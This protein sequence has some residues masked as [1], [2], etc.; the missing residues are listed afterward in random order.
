MI[1]LHIHSNYSDGSNTVVEILK[2]SE[3]AKLDIISITDH[4]TC[5]AYRDVE[6]HK[7]LF[8]GSI[9]PGIEMTT[10]FL[11][12]RIE[13]LGYDFDNYELINEYFEKFYKKFDMN[14][15]IKK[16]RKVFLDFLV[17]EK[18]EFDNSFYK[19]LDTFLF[20]SEVYESMLIMN[21]NLEELLADEYVELS[22]DFFRKK[23]CNPKSKFFIDYTYMFPK[24]TD[25]IE[26]IHKNNGKTFLAHP[27]LY[28]FDLDY[29]LPKLIKN[30]KID[31]LECFHTKCNLEQSNYLI[32]FTTT[33]NLLKSGGSDFHGSA[34]EDYFFSKVMYGTSEIENNIIEDWRKL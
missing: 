29:Y 32:D 6:V 16:I 1:D 30:T 12:Y 27:F 28:G 23:T 5:L 17:S 4:D 26:L 31:G 11:G 2:M 10:S 13:V 14:S 3:A 20:E 34:R 18:I 24:I 33:N 8:S 22:R 25:V 21:D 9:K 19:K 15:E 7:N